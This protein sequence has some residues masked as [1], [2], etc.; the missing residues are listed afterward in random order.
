MS[1]EEYEKAIET[2]RGYDEYTDIKLKPIQ[3][4]VGQLQWEVSQVKELTAERDELKKRL[5]EELE[6]RTIV[7]K[8][9]A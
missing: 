3:I 8:G 2:L 9:S 6:L 4:Y 1:K 7:N 5:D